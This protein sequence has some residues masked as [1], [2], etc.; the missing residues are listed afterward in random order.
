MMKAWEGK[1]EEEVFMS[2]A[3]N[4]ETGASAWKELYTWAG[5]AAIISELVIFLGIVTYFI[6]PYAPG[7]KTTESIFL[8]LQSNPF[9][10]LVSLDLF[11]ILGNLFSILTFLALYVSLRQVNESYALI[12]LVVGLV[13]V[14][15]LFPSRP[16]FELFALS[17]QYAAATTDTARSQLLAA[18]D[19][20]LSLFDGTGWFM[21]TLLGALSLL[22]S[23]LLMLRSKTYSN[24]TAYAGIITNVVVC[25]FFLP[26]LGKFLLF[27]SLPG[28]MIWYFLLA[29][30]F[31]RLS[32]SA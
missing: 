13:G 9:G 19:G 15:L 30:S 18:G 6:W 8:L 11:L 10:G 20:L 1:I 14:V 27:L 23:S 28:Y 29:R 22:A 5:I 4:N 21:N 3:A 2:Q 24:P 25:G 7:S 26:V 12:A 32:R 31:F 16:I 17:R